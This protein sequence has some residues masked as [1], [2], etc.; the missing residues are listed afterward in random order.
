MSIRL[1]W[2]R[3]IQ[4]ETGEGPE[5]VNVGQQEVVINDGD[6][7]MLGIAVFP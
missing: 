4:Q 1:G 7:Q 5:Y 3:W 6:Q 2:S